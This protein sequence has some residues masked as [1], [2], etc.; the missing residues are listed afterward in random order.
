MVQVGQ[1]Q[2]CT[3][4]VECAFSED[5]VAAVVALFNGI[6]DVRR[7]ISRHVIVAPYVAI[8]ISG[9]RHWERLVRFLWRKVDIW[10][11]TLMF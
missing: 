8:P 10:P 6:E 7:I 11:G 3:D 2:R 1:I 4:Y 9:R 5:D